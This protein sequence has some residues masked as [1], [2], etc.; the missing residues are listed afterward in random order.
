MKLI[1]QISQEISFPQSELESALQIARLHVKRFTIKKK[2]GGKRY[3]FQPERRVKIIQ[4][5]LIENFFS[6]I[7]IHQGAMA[8]RKNTSTLDNAKSHAQYR[9]FVKVDLENFFPSIKF[10]DL[11]LALEQLQ[12]SPIPLNEDSL[13]VIQLCCFDKNDQLPIGYPT[14]PIISNIV[15]KDF[16]NKVTLMLHKLGNIHYTR[17]ADDMIFSTN[18]AGMAGSILSGIKDVIA[19]SSSPK[20][21]LNDKKTRVSSASAGNTYVT[22]LKIHVSGKVGVPKNYRDKVRLL[23]NLKRK[24]KLEEKELLELKGHLNY[25][26]SVDPSL[27]TRLSS[28]Y[29]DIIM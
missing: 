13:N 24:G 17:Y 6:K 26:R 5:W 7:P 19:S 29:V 8:Y 14:S 3:I 15:M 21:K 1:E 9:F 2:N 16:D 28:K 10:D 18:I 4:Y 20:I 27:Y 23:L 11:K 12:S 22:G 25:L